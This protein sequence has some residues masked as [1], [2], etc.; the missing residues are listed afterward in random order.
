[1]NE[2]DHIDKIKRVRDEYLTH[3]QMPSGQIIALLPRE[4][5]FK[6]GPCSGGI[7]V[8]TSDK[9]YFERKRMELIESELIRCKCREER[10]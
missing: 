4:Y 7:V 3:I 2:K 5:T 9:D 1:M 10:T 8:L 6:D